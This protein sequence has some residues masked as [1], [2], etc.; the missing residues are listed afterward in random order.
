MKLGVQHPHSV[1]VVP[2]LKKA[3]T[4]NKD[5]GHISVVDLAKKTVTQ[6]PTP[7]GTE[8]IISDGKYIFAG[9][10]Q[11]RSWTFRNGRSFEP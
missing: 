11:S 8:G 1:T 6:I 10:G 7:T 9:N 4:A 2:S 5:A 3:Y